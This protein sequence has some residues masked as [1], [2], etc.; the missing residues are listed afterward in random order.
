MSTNK[1]GERPTFGADDTLEH[2]QARLPE[3]A[4]TPMESRKLRCK[5]L[6]AGVLRFC[7]IQ[8]CRVSNRAM[9]FARYQGTGVQA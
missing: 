3:V 8:L 1:H 7:P 2:T 4:E 6:I 5:I 9:H